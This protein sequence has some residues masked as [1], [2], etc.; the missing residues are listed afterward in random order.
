MSKLLL[1]GA[2]IFIVASNSHADSGNGTNVVTCFLG[3]QAEIGNGIQDFETGVCNRPRII[4]TVIHRNSRDRFC[5]LEILNALR[6]S[7]A[8]TY[9]Q[10]V[11]HAFNL[12][13][14]Q[15]SSNSHFFMTQTQIGLF[16]SGNVHSLVTIDRS[17]CRASIDSL[18][19]ELNGNQAQYLENNAAAID[20]NLVSN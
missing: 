16:R 12:N 6:N 8:E 4:S 18:I 14:S 7:H 3:G 10:A 15:V 5:H 9:N 20:E 13:R 19:N 1:F 2:F 11:M 17:D